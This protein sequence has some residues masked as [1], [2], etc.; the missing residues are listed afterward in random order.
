MTRGRPAKPSNEDIAGPLKFDAF[1]ILNFEL[2]KNP[3]KEITTDLLKRKWAAAA[4]NQALGHTWMY[5]W[6]NV[7]LSKT[8]TPQ[9]LYNKPTKSFYLVGI[10][11]LVAKPLTN[12]G[13]TICKVPWKGSQ[14]KVFTTKSI[15]WCVLDVF[16]LR[17]QGCYANRSFSIK[18]GSESEKWRGQVPSCSWGTMITTYKTCKSGRKSARKSVLAILCTFCLHSSGHDTC[19][20][21]T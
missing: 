12:P 18:N 11:H 8:R 16:F 21:A 17:V 1:W 2:Q 19:P 9:K 14:Q 13:L 4:P 6:Y 15:H 7:G 20:G 5:L 10:Q 3:K